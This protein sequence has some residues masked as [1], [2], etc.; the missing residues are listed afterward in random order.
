MIKFR[1]LILIFCLLVVAIASLFFGFRKQEHNKPISV[2]NI[3][4]VPVFNSHNNEEVKEEVK[5]VKDAHFDS[6]APFTLSLEETGEVIFNG[7]DL[8]E[9][10]VYFKKECLYIFLNPTDTS[11]PSSFKCVELPSFNYLYFPEGIAA[12][13]I[14][15]D[16]RSDFVKIW[17]QGDVNTV[18]S[19]LLWGFTDDY[20]L[21]ELKST[22]G[23]NLT[24]E[25]ADAN[26]GGGQLGMGFFEENKIIY[27]NNLKFTNV[28][29]PSESCEVITWKWLGNNMFSFDKVETRK[30]EMTFCGS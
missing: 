22:D 4:V 24:R 6:T 18:S 30:Q 25:F 13:D 9:P 26:P 27:K 19:G 23:K 12:F 21:T 14:N 15:G 11:K 17:Q 10:E 3:Q 28:G 20:S 5:F 29:E 1:T 2:G 7:V 8:F 16:T